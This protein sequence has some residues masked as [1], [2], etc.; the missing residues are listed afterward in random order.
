MTYTAPNSAQRAPYSN[1][2]LSTSP[3]FILFLIWLLSVPFYKLNVV[4]TW[5]IDNILAPLLFAAWMV[6]IPLRTMSKPHSRQVLIV[7]SIIALYLFLDLLDHK[8]SHEPTPLLSALWQELKV[9]LYLVLPVLYIQNIVQFRRAL[10]ILALI[11]GVA[12]L[13]AIAAAAGLV[14]I[15]YAI[16]EPRLNIGLIRTAGVVGTFG[17]L[18]ALVV[19]ALLASFALA[20][21]PESTL[22]RRRY[23]RWFLYMILF[24]GMLAA[25]SRNMVLSASLAVTTYYLLLP[26]S[27]RSSRLIL[28]LYSFGLLVATLILVLFGL[29]I[30]QL[31]YDSIVGTG[32]TKGSVL[33]RLIS[34]EAAWNLITQEP[35][36]GPASLGPVIFN[37]IERTIHNFWLGILFKGGIFGFIPIATLFVISLYGS[38]SRARV[39]TLRHEAIAML[40]LTLALMFSS[41]FYVAHN[42]LLF[43]LCIGV[44]LSLSGLSTNTNTDPALESGKTGI[45]APLVWQHGVIPRRHRHNA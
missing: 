32:S 34:Y 29:P 8:L 40:A 23:I 26:V 38:L 18:T 15:D 30:I 44:T 2:K 45:N 21:K 27:T 14:H 24:A 36:F 22:L 10:G 25:Q 39:P 35:W 17:S 1:Q 42:T 43:W 20:Q 3:L 11:A 28:L 9:L 6:T 41:F 5:S 12:C 7:L 19:T 37:D 4:G 13:S 33:D 16:A 31:A